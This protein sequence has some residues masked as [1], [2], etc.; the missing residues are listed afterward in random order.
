ME[1]L[2]EC[3]TFGTIQVPSNGMPIIL[4]A[5]RQTS[6]GYPKLGQVITADLPKLAQMKP[7]EKIQFQLVTIKEAEALLF[8]LESRIKEL[9][10]GLRLEGIRTGII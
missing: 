7:G 4:M 2:S 1:Q 3:V 6:G 5:D 9:K 8:D 10:L